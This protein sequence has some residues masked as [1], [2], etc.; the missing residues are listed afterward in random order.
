MQN[1]IT[2]SEKETKLILDIEKDVNRATVIIPTN[3]FPKT[4]VV[5]G[6]VRNEHGKNHF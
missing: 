5:L 1:A 3:A 4:I 6:K 2:L